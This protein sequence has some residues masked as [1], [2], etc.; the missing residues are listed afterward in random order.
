MELWKDDFLDDNRDYCSTAPCVECGAEGR[1][2]CIC[3][4]SLCQVHFELQAGFCSQV[5]DEAHQ[6]ALNEDES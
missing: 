3:G 6:R 1:D 4:A 5:T 2:A